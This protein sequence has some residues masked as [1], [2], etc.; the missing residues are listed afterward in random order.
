M[1]PQPA[2]V[3][4]DQIVLLSSSKLTQKHIN[5]HLRLKGCKSWSQQLK[6]DG[7]TS[8]GR[9]LLEGYSR[10]CE[11]AFDSVTAPSGFRN[12]F[13]LTLSP[14]LLV[15][16]NTR[17]ELEMEQVLLTKSKLLVRKHKHLTCLKS[18]AHHPVYLDVPKYSHFRLRPIGAEWQWSKPV[19]SD[20]INGT[21]L[22]LEQAGSKH[23]VIVIKVVKTAQQKHLVL[24]EL[25]DINPEAGSR[26]ENAS[27]AHYLN[28][29]QHLDGKRP[30]HFPLDSRCMVPPLQ[31]SLLCL[32]FPSEP[33]IVDIDLLLP[34]VHS[35]RVG[36]F[37]V[38]S[39]TGL[40]L[41]K[42]HNESNYGLIRI[43]TRTAPQKMPTGAIKHPSIVYEGSAVVAGKWRKDSQ[44]LQ[45]RS[46]NDDKKHGSIASLALPKPNPSR[47]WN[48]PASELRR[49]VYAGVRLGSEST[50]RVLTVGYGSPGALKDEK[51]SSD[52]VAAHVNYLDKCLNVL[53]TR[54][55]DSGMDIEELAKLLRAH[56]DHLRAWH[57]AILAGREMPHAEVTLDRE[58]LRFELQLAGVGIS[59]TGA[60]LP[61]KVV[62]Q[63]PATHDLMYI[64]MR[65]IYSEARLF[66]LGRLEFE[67]QMTN[68]QVDNQLDTR[69][70]VLF[71]RHV[72]GKSR[73]HA[74]R[75]FSLARIFKGNSEVSTRQHDK[76]I[77]YVAMTQLLGHN[78]T[79]FEY[80]NV[81]LQEVD[82]T[83]DTNF[84]NMLFGYLIGLYEKLH[85][86]KTHNSVEKFQNL[87]VDRS[88]ANRMN[89][90]T[91]EMDW[92]C[93]QPLKIN[94]RYESTGAFKLPQSVYVP[95]IV[96]FAVQLYTFLVD[97]RMTVKMASFCIDNLGDSPDEIIHMLKMFYK[98]QLLSSARDSGITALKIAAAQQTFEDDKIA[99]VKSIF[100]DPELG[101]T[102]RPNEYAGI[103]SQGGNEL[104]EKIIRREEEFIR[105]GVDPVAEI[106]GG[107]TNL[108][109]P[110]TLDED[111]QTSLNE[112]VEGPKVVKGIKRVRLGF[113]S[114]I[115]GVVRRPM[116]RFED[117]S[118]NSTGQAVGGIFRGVYEGVV[119]LAVKPALGVVG[120][121]RDLLQVK[122]DVLTG[123]VTEPMRLPRLITGENAAI[124]CPYNKREAFGHQLMR[125]LTERF[126]WSKTP[127]GQ[128]VFH[129]RLLYKRAVLSL[130]LTTKSLLCYQLNQESGTYDRSPGRIRNFFPLRRLLHT[131]AV[132]TEKNIVKVTEQDSGGSHEF[133]CQSVRSA[134]TFAVAVAKIAK[135]SPLYFNGQIQSTSFQDRDYRLL[136]EWLVRI[137]TKT[138]PAHSKALGLANHVIDC[139]D[140]VLGSNF[141]VRSHSDESMK[142]IQ[143]TLL[144]DGSHGE[145]YEAAMQRARLLDITSIAE[146]TP[147]VD[148]EP[149]V[150]AP[151]DADTNTE[152]DRDIDMDS[153]DGSSLIPA[154][155]MI[156][157]PSTRHVRD[158]KDFDE[159]YSVIRATTAHFKTPSIC[160]RP[161]SW[162]DVGWA[163]GFTFC[164]ILYRLLVIT[165]GLTRQLRINFVRT[166]KK[167]ALEIFL[168]V[169]RMFELLLEVPAP[170]CSTLQRWT[171]YASPSVNSPVTCLPPN[172]AMEIRFYALQIREACVHITAPR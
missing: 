48:S 5:L 145:G 104:V 45:V 103:R 155:R 171:R 153:D 149:M 14:A 133:H 18:Q 160:V 86:Y 159:W 20:V 62:P 158:D 128:Y 64:S 170:S 92:L 120:G 21:T 7:D 29:V 129:T 108:V 102:L 24:Q 36:F 28:V 39:I 122:S 112:P 97:I 164:D 146:N 136:R 130:V 13:V 46:L 52:M 17:Y 32:P 119:G 138:G 123:G 4:E 134:Q 117:R 85:R 162:K 2:N 154:R 57:N 55:T 71:G 70:P 66:A 152:S 9:V 148:F 60:K 172:V 84:L 88:P 137:E 42:P 12:T 27:T 99:G 156:M 95:K 67:L 78:S 26:V 100:Y 38:G 51:P 34:R 63:A 106:L 127:L 94:L 40:D 43:C 61:G 126:D 150:D 31:A 116:H 19:D 101:E 114:A 161:R 96:E 6:I 83:I 167:P 166:I 76:P 37:K 22:L 144:D 121:A 3:G 113:S 65:G 124:L 125:N 44:P 141:T 8:A 58:Q 147:A 132:T 35:G 25:Y 118:I 109:A 11:I 111:F 131:K 142:Q 107:V 115:T 87:L 151:F 163:F 80:L 33:P 135:P 23:L 75:K 41:R 165:N 73:S 49:V 77:L 30:K 1:Q 74:S 168:E 140:D 157:T 105:T 81:L 59:L 15:T 69:N 98:A 10:K 169:S 91:V 139:L 50:D 89:T 56:R 79:V 16:N 143:D 47:F 68:I 54:G 110:V 90:S 93:I 53:D 82:L 72:P